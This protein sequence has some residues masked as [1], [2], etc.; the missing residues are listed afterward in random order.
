MHTEAL[1]Q[2]LFEKAIRLADGRP[3]RQLQ[4]V[5]GEAAGLT[6]ERLQALFD[7]FRL[8]TLASEAA[9]V[10]QGEP[11]RALCL[12]CSQESD[13]R[14]EQEPCPSCGSHRRRMVA[15]HHLALAGVS[16]AGGSASSVAGRPRALDRTARI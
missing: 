14:S 10:V 12:T 15:G 2:A 4:V 7:Q 3:I 5:L 1:A 13:A 6:P 9:L 11:G 16:L 8:G